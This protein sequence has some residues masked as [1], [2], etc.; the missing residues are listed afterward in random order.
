M[1]PDLERILD[2]RRDITVLYFYQTCIA[3]LITIVRNS[4]LQAWKEFAA[5]VRSIEVKWDLG[6]LILKAHPAHVCAI[7]M[8]RRKESSCS[9][10]LSERLIDKGHTQF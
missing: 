5:L 10:L 4:V 9:A 3:C 7:N 2:A 8:Y 6:L 1:L